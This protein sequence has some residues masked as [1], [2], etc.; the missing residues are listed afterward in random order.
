MKRYT[1]S[2]FLIFTIV[3]CLEVGEKVEAKMTKHDCFNFQGEV[4]KVLEVTKKNY[5]Y[6]VLSSDNELI[7]PIA[8]IDAQGSAVDCPNS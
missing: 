5:R 3:S 6:S 8:I 7:Y 1:S 2:I 4:N